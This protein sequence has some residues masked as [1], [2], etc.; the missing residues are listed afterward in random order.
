MPQQVLRWFT[1]LKNVEWPRTD[2]NKKSDHRAA[3]SG[4]ALGLSGK[5]PRI[6]GFTNPT[7]QEESK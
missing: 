5:K 4:L 1:K 7:L 2:L 6:T 3:L